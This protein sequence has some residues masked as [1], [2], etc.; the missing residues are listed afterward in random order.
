MNR[1]GR[2]R[3]ER[4]GATVVEQPVM[5]KF[6]YFGAAAGGG[7]QELFTIISLGEPPPEAMLKV[8]QQ[9]MAAQKQLTAPRPAFYTEQELHPL[10]Q[11]APPAS[12]LVVPAGTRRGDPD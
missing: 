8:Q 12:G 1:A 11:P 5:K 7:V 3:A 9:L 6:V 2:R 4:K 10:A